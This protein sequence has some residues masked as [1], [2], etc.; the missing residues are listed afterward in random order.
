[1][2]FVLNPVSFSEFQYV[3]SHSADIFTAIQYTSY[4]VEELFWPS[5]PRT[6]QLLLPPGI[7]VV[8]WRRRDILV[9]RAGKFSPLTLF[10]FLKSFRLFFSSTSST[11]EADMGDTWDATVRLAKSTAHVDVH[12][13]KQHG[14]ALAA[15]VRCALVVS[16]EVGSFRRISTLLREEI[17]GRIH[18]IL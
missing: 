12:L 6:R 16:S 1:M 15:K 5:V 18:N 2:R 7:V 3:V 10:V 11:L 9:F 8:R 14:D 4:R 13:L 17:Y